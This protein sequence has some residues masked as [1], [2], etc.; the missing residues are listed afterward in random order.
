MTVSVLVSEVWLIMSDG[1]SVGRILSFLVLDIW[2]LDLLVWRIENIKCS[3]T[4]VGSY[5]IMIGLV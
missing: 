1:V 5:C 4:I 2:Q 3:V